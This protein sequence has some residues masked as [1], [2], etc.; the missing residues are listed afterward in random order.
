MI[1]QYVRVDV[2]GYAYTAAWT[3]QPFLTIGQEVVIQTHKETSLRGVV[4]REVA[5]IDHDAVMTVLNRDTFKEERGRKR[6]LRQA[7]T[8][9]GDL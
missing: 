3:E 2:S 7:V 6:Q 1:T 9:F 8:D 5:Q 4:I